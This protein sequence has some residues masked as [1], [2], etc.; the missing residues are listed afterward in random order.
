MNTVG[1]LNAADISIG[2]TMTVTSTKNAPGFVGKPLT[3][4]GVCLPF[5]IVQMPG[6]LNDTFT[7]MIDSREC[8]FA[9]LSEQYIAAYNKMKAGD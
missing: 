3:V 4:V 6:V 7:A 8:E 1:E 5:L 9:T 2:M